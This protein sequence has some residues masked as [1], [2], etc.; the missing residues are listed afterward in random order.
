MKKWY[1]IS[2]FQNILKFDNSSPVKEDEL[3]K[4][5]IGDPNSGDGDTIKEAMEKINRNFEKLQSKNKENIWEDQLKK[6]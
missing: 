5:N 2:S 1:G 6:E 3:E 4:I